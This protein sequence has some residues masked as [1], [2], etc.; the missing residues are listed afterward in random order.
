VTASDFSGS[1][2]LDTSACQSHP[3]KS[4]WAF[5]FA[6]LGVLKEIDLLP[7]GEGT[8]RN[9]WQPTA[10]ALLTM[11][12]RTQPVAIHGNGFGL[13]LRFVRP[14]DLPLIATGCNHGAP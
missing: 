13:F 1:L 2:E 8:S 7:R 3:V 5:G 12:R 14:R 9:G 11:E 4:L 10:D 6:G